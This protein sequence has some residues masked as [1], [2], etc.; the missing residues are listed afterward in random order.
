M[1]VPQGVQGRY[2]V[3][4]MV[5]HRLCMLVQRSFHVQD[6]GRRTALS[7]SAQCLAHHGLSWIIHGVCLL[8][9]LLRHSRSAGAVSD[10]EILAARLSHMVRDPV[11]GTQGDRLEAHKVILDQRSFYFCELFDQEFVSFAGDILYRPLL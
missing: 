7:I 10:T 3:S 8:R 2:H 4:D 6:V 9:L 5:G 1:R 11:R